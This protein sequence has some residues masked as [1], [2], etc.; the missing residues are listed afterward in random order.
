MTVFNALDYSIETLEVFPNKSTDTV[1]VGMCFVGTVGQDIS[2]GRTADRD[3]VDVQNGGMGYLGLKN[4]GDIVVEDQDGV[5]PT[6]RQGD[7]SEGTEG[8]LKGGIVS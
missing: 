6:H 8:G 2:S 1:V 5:H 3:I 4:I 7:K